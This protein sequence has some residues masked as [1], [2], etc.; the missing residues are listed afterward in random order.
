M[1]FMNNSDTELEKEFGPYHVVH[2]TRGRIRLRVPRLAENSSYA[3]K[4][5]HLIGSYL[6]VDEVSI[7]RQA[8]SVVVRYQTS[9]ISSHQLQEKLAIAFQKAEA[10]AIEPHSTS[11]LAKRLGVSFQAITWHRSQPHFAKWSRE[12]DP[13]EIAW[14]YDGS[15]KSFSPI[16]LSG[17][18]LSP[19][20]SKGGQILVALGGAT[21]SKV[22]AM[23][24][25]FTGEAL[26]WLLM[27]TAGMVMGA[28]VGAFVGEVVGAELG[29]M[30]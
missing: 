1:F 12:R 9:Q 7:N 27:G 2:A 4:L 10:P 18:C 13:E 3:E 29:S 26:G 19:S 11:A 16:G 20:P 17:N 28:E 5:E 24:G 23:V 22:G 8:R 25:K 15:S 6:C 14:N 21:S 30:L